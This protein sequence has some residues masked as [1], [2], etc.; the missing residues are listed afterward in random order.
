[1]MSA[2]KHILLIAGEESGDQYAAHLAQ[3]LLATHSE[4]TI[5]GIAG[6][7]LKATGVPLLYDLAHLG[8]TGLWDVV[9]HLHVI[10]AANQALQRYLSQHPV[11][12]LILIDYPGFN[13]RVA[14]SVK[15]QYPNTR[16][17]YYIS[18]QI[19]AWK[20]KRIEIIRRCVDHMAVIFPFEQPLYAKAGVAASFVGHPLVERINAELATPIT[21]SELGLPTNKR[22][23]ALLPGSRRSEIKYHMPVLRDTAIRLSQQYPDLHFV[24]PI[25]NSLDPEI[26][27]AHWTPEAPACT[28]LLSQS[29]P[30]IRCS[31]VVI[32]SSGTASLECAL[33]G[34][35]MCIIYKGALLNYLILNQVIR[36]RYLGLCNILK[37][38]MIVP[39]LLQYDCTAFELSKV[40]GQFLSQPAFCQAIEANLRQLKQELSVQHATINLLQL[41]N[42]QL[43]ANSD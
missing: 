40:V 20:A 38:R 3:Q 29:L 32:V 19:W 36:V 39:E 4:L 34:K 5:A 8:L 9:K 23:I 11:D 13:L 24:M 43:H 30:A 35:P 21:R 18:P 1:M 7:H 26:V 28:F 37:S 16:I 2:S 12:L 15:K 17:L 27:K 42:Q 14:Q 41:V 33:L 25:A 31:D 22:I 6:Q 10:R